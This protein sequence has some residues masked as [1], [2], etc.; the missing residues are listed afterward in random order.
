VRILWRV[1]L[2]L[3]GLAVVGAFVLVMFGRDPSPPPGLPPIE[4]RAGSEQPRMEYRRAKGWFVHDYVDAF[5]AEMGA[6]GENPWAYRAFAVREA[7]DPGSGTFPFSIEFAESSVD[8]VREVRVAVTDDSD[9][10]LSAG[11]WHDLGT[12]SLVEKDGW[13]VARL[14]RARVDTSTTT[15]RVTAVYR[16]GTDW[17]FGR[18][19]PMAPTVVGRVRDRIAS[20]VPFRWLPD[21]R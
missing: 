21:L 20:W 2:V 3:V 17:S 8:R 16:D 9:A 10:D 11:D 1:A 15:Y 18:T 6:D 5:G 12:T 7:V 13:T 14:E 4:G 19:I